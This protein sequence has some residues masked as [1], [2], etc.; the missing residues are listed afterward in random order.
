MGTSIS[1][2][3]PGVLEHKIALTQKHRYLIICGTMRSS[4]RRSRRLTPWLQL[5]VFLLLLTPAA[6]PDDYDFA[7]IP[8]DVAGP[9]GSTVGW[10][11]SI[12]NKSAAD[13]LVLTKL[14]AGT[15]DHGTPDNLFDYPVVAPDTT[16]N[17]PFVPSLTGLFELTWDLTAPAGFVDSGTFD[18]GGEWWSGNPLDP[19]ATATF[20]GDAPDKTAAYS[21]VVTGTAAVPEPAP[22]FV[23]WLV[24]VFM[25]LH[26]TSPR[27]SSK[28]HDGIRPR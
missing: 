17:Q 4:R 3:A 28:R 18:V 26:K 13:W 6:F 7:V 16:V 25:L 10:G 9:P 15:F 24:A 12:T 21:A 19:L 23:L 8:T 22:G 14:D 1:T 5:L 20:L 2:K 11:Y 27:S